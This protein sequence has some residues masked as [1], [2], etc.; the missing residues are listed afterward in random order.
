L[1]IHRFSPDPTHVTN[2]VDDSPGD[3]IA[4]FGRR[5]A[6]NARNTSATPAAWL[7]V[8]LLPVWLV[9]AW[10]H[11]GPFGGALRKHPSW[12]E[13]SMVLALASIIGFVVNDTIGVAGLGFTYLSAA[14]IYPALRERWRTATS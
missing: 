9:V 13:A 2:V 7:V 3:I 12:R 8:A 6:L 10:K 5:L 1:L 14:L 4:T 11:L